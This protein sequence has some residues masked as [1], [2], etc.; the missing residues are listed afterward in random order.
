MRVSACVRACVACMRTCVCVKEI[1]IHETVLWWEEGIVVI[2]VVLYI[3]LSSARSSYNFPV[4][5]TIY[6]LFLVVL[7]LGFLVV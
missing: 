6:Y 5:R 3:L 4:G 1:L 7:V 2:V